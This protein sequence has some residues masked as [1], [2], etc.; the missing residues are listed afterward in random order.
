MNK[1]NSDRY[2]TKLKLTLA[3]VGLLATM[4]GAGLLGKE[5]EASPALTSPDTAAQPALTA[6]SVSNVTIDSSIPPDLDLNLE[7]IPTVSA[8][9]VPSAPIMRSSPVAAGRSSA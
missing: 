1:S 2:L 9:S 6:R 7:A 5:V 4:I 8:P 3:A